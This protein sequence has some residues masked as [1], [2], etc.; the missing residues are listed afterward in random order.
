MK[1]HQIQMVGAQTLQTAVDAV[2]NRLRCP[3]FTFVAPGHVA[4]LGCQHVLLAPVGDGASDQLLTDVI[5]GSGVEKVD[6]RIQGRVEDVRGLGFLGEGQ[7]MS[8]L[9][10][11]NTQPADLES[12]FAQN[13]FLH[14]S[15][16]PFQW[17]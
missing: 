10:Q 1:L 13:P 6:A 2:A 5:A 3:L 12:G 17:F 16:R 4:A 14:L 7:L 9:C 8:D 15:F 11:P